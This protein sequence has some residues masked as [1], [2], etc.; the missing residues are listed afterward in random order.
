MERISADVGALRCHAWRTFAGLTHARFQG[1][2]VF[3]TWYTDD[4]AFTHK[5]L[6][7]FP[8]EGPWSPILTPPIQMTP[9]IAPVNPDSARAATDLNLSGADILR[10]TV[11]YNRAAYEFIRRQRLYDRDRIKKWRDITRDIPDFPNDSIVIKLTWWPIRGDDVSVLPVW[12]NHPTRPVDYGI[13]NDGDD[14]HGNNFI[15]WKRAV[16]IIPDGLKGDWP[17]HTSIKYFDYRAP[18]PTQLRTIDRVPVIPMSQLYSLSAKQL[19]G[20]TSGFDDLFESL[21][22]PGRTFRKECN[23]LN[24]RGSRN[25]KCRKCDY[26]VLVAMHVATKELKDWVWSTFWWHDRGNIGEFA[27]HRPRSVKDPWR[28]YLMDMTVDPDV[29]REKNRRPNITFNPWLEGSMA[30]GTVSNCMACHQRS[31]IPQDGHDLRQTVRRGALPL[32]HRYYLKEPHEEGRIRVDYLWSIVERATKLPSNQRH[33]L[34]QSS[35]EPDGRK[36]P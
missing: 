30:K 1:R 28:N 14:A 11:L 24:C 15:Y 23:E 2:P 8:I 3:T 5:Q 19:Q 13:P 25:R 34:P 18:D 20:S 16:A 4:E 12:D 27:A 17:D 9:S 33:D 36:G 29:P 35:E 6:P 22:G 10:T 21:Y 31:A 7:E 26:V 32:D